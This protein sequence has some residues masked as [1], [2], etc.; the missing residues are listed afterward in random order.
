MPPVILLRVDRAVLP[1]RRRRPTLGVDNLNWLAGGFAAPARGIRFLVLDS[2]KYK[3]A[4][5]CAMQQFKRI[6]ETL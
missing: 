2:V 5:Y 4:E 1:N 6:A 3:I